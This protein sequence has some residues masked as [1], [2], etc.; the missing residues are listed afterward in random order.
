MSAT[1]FEPLA[2]DLWSAFRW[3]RDRD[4]IGGTDDQRVAWL[5]AEAGLRDL[6]NQEAYE[7]DATSAD[8]VTRHRYTNFIV[9]LMPD[10][11]EAWLTAYVHIAAT[12]ASGRLESRYGRCLGRCEYSGGRWQVAQWHSP[13][14][15]VVRDGEAIVDVAPDARSSEPAEPLPQAR[16][17]AAA[18]P[19]LTGGRETWQALR[20]DVW[21]AHHWL[22][23][24]DV[25]E[26]EDRLQRLSDELEIREL[27]SNYAYAHD[28]RD[29]A[30]SG[31]MF[32]DD[33]MLANERWVLSGNAQVVGAFREWNRNMHLSF[34]RFSNPIIRFVPNSPEAWFIAYFHVAHSGLGRESYGY[35]RYFGRFT[36]QSGRWQIAD[37]RIANDTRHVFPEG[38]A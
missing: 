28:S 22:L 29:L 6:L 27:L 36:K 38:S 13:V 30:W 26:P 3:V 18:N 8:P 32:S 9:R 16:A 21:A 11:D 37:W 5:W 34:H 17:S 4:A 20:D 25:A 12:F 10:Q 14:D 15:F 24:Q 19:P 35:G 23:D 1:R 7:S 33:A 31:S 2:A